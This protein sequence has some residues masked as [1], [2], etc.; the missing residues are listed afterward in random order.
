MAA[1][2]AKPE[3]VGPGQEELGHRERLDRPAQPIHPVSYPQ[4][5]WGRQGFRAR[6]WQ[7]GFLAKKCHLS[8]AWRAGST[9]SARSRCVQTLTIRFLAKSTTPAREPY[10]HLPSHPISD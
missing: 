8:R 4:G 2:H 7:H 3:I 5:V 10:Q 1:H 6:E 9:S